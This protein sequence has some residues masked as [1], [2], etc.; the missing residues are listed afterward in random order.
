MKAPRIRPTVGRIV[1]YFEDSDTSK[2]PMA[3]QVCHVI[4]DQIVNLSAYDYNGKPFSRTG[5]QLVQEGDYAMG[6]HC[7]WMPHQVAEAERRAAA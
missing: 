5:I 3:A 1:W 2:P 4:N 7:R 6:R